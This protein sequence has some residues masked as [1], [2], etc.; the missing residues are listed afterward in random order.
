[1]YNTAVPIFKMKAAYIF[2]GLEQRK[3]LYAESGFWSLWRGIVSLGQEFERISSACEKNCCFHLQGYVCY[4]FQMCRNMAKKQV[5]FLQASTHD[6]TLGMNDKCHVRSSFQCQGQQMASIPIL[7]TST[8]H[9]P[10]LKSYSEF[11]LSLFLLVYMLCVHIPIFVPVHSF[12]REG[13]DLC[14]RLYI[15]LYIHHLSILCL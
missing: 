12:V 10:V 5:Q 4:G 13:A 8:S 7:L 11:S 1:M 14:L 3:L 2:W 6:Y 15:I 9:V